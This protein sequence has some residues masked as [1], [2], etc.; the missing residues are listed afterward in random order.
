MKI[1]ILGSTGFV[2]SELLK[3]SIEKGHQIKV[4][5]RN[6]GKL[7]E[8]AKSVEVVEGNYFDKDKVE[9]TITGAD[10]VISAIGPS[11]KK[12]EGTEEYEKAMTNL[13]ASMKNQ[14]ISRI[15]ILGGAATPVKDNEIFNFRQ[16]FIGFMLNMMGKYMIQIKTRECAILAASGLDWIIVRPPRVSQ[17]SPKNNVAAYESKLQSM[18]ID[19]AD[20]V[21]FIL[22]QTASDTWL[23]K[24]PLVCSVKKR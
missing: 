6:P 11:T 2:G 24:A 22:E 7:G 15:I 12:T 17:G 20:L 14:K 1:A 18:Q 3:K 4:L 5:A 8:C 10:I 9:K 19:R 16:K 23:H 21:D 13:T